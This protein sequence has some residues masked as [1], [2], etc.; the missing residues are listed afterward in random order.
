MKKGIL[1]CILR[2][3][4]RDFENNATSE[5]ITKFKKKYSGMRWQETLE[6]DIL[7]YANTVVALE[8]WTENVIKFMVEQGI[9]K[10]GEDYRI[11]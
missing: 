11:I 6:K 3:L 10:E 1:R 9:A 2:T 7:R 4:L 5:Q 8:R